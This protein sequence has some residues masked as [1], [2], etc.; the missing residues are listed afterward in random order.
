MEAEDAEA[1]EAEEEIIIED[2][3][4][5]EKAREKDTPRNGRSKDKQS[6]KHATKRYNLI[7]K[8]FSYEF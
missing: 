5:K 2:D 7:L 3:K 4:G 8:F 1:D 6:S